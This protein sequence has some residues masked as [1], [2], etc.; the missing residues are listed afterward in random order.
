MKGPTIYLWPEEDNVRAFHYDARTKFNTKAL[1]GMMGNKG[2]PGGFLSVSANGQ[3]DGIL[4]AAIPYKDDA[5]VE[6]VRGTLRAFDAN[7]LQLLW[8]T[9]RQRTGG[10]LRF[11]Q[12][13]AA[14]R[15]QRQGVSAHVFGP[16]ECVRAACPERSG[17]AEARRRSLSKDPRH[18]GHV[19]GASGHAG[20]GKN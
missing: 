7:T 16:A 3:D 14:D 15:G 1:N 10:Q 18:R 2:M 12:V 4:W 17:Q 11:R 5:W 6:I 13:C 9:R 20:H 8:S 19:K